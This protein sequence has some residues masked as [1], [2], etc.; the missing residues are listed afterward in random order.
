MKGGA[1]MTTRRR[2]QGKT[3]D[4]KE[5]TLHGGFMRQTAGVAVEDYRRWQTSGFMKKKTEGLIIATQEQGLRANSIN[6]SIDKTSETH[7]CRLFGDSI[8]TRQL[9]Y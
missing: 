6:H 5:T 8:E 3:R 1:S 2:Q 9:S 4:W 7:L